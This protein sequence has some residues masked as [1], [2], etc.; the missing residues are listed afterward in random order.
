M[1]A[2]LKTVG[3]ILTPAEAT[4]TTRDDSFVKTARALFLGMFVAASTDKA[5]K[6]HLLN[7]TKTRHNRRLEM[8]LHRNSADKVTLSSATAADAVL[9]AA[10]AA[11]ATA[12]PALAA[13]AP[14]GP[15]SAAGTTGAS[16]MSS[17]L[18]ARVQKLRAE[19]AS[20][21]AA[22]ESNAE[23]TMDQM[24]ARRELLHFSGGFQAIALLSPPA[25]LVAC[26]VDPELWRAA[27]SN[28]HRH[29]I[30]SWNDAALGQGFAAENALAVAWDAVPAGL[31]GY[32]PAA[33]QSYC[34]ACTRLREEASYAAH[35]GSWLIC[36][37]PDRLKLLKS[38]LV[39]SRAEACS[40]VRAAIEHLMP[41][42]TI[43]GAYALTTEADKSAVPPAFTKTLDTGM[44]S[45]NSKET[46]LGI[47][48]STSR[49]VDVRTG[50]FSTTA[51][52]ILQHTEGDLAKACGIAG[53]VGSIIGTVAV[54]GA[55][56]GPADV[57]SLP[58]AVAA[59][60]QTITAASA[61]AFASSSHASAAGYC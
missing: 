28:Y 5:S 19:A 22:I 16:A 2:H 18:R 54:T 21:L 58:P 47:I 34:D 27:C 6:G 39:G 61:K 48:A 56:A 24:K 60:V 17:Q 44:A 46:V 3:I 53:E 12:A 52:I 59:K 43:L 35:E 11:L 8:F 42:H 49:G 40:Y 57:A 32:F 33:V 7:A 31:K 45:L 38:K 25:P 51:D 9:A 14:V 29:A 1:A 15:Q 41:L 55:A 26:Y 30:L 20:D 13:A 37:N 23:T 4:N 10:E 50:D 36:V